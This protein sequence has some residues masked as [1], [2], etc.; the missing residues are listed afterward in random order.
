MQL[1]LAALMRG[2]VKVEID[3]KPVEMLVPPMAQL[4]A[5]NALLDRGYGRPPQA[6]ELIGK[7]GGAIQT[8]EVDP[9]EIIETCLDAL[10]ERLLAAGY[11]LL[12]PCAARAAKQEVLRL[13]IAGCRMA[14]PQR[15]AWRR[16][17]AAVG[18]TARNAHAHHYNPHSSNRPSAFAGSSLIRYTVCRD[19]PAAFEIALGVTSWASILRMTSNFSRSKLGLRPR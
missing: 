12:Q 5:A 18:G 10:R 2:V 19:T 4:A 1:G 11:P 17:L 7:D 14:P 13:A 9:V 3:G 16:G 15:P 6:V 8:E